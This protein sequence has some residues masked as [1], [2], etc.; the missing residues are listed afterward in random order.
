M[1]EY[2]IAVFTNFALSIV[3]QNDH[4]LVKIICTNQLISNNIFC[5]TKVGGNA[6]PRAPKPPNREAVIKWFKE[7]EI[8]KGSGLVPDTKHVAVWF[9]GK[10]M[11][12]VH[13]YHSFAQR[14]DHLP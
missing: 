6:K 2:R 4:I 7:V 10:V 1:Y 13:A 12:D 3:G 14:F 9:H 11:P 5:S 8:P